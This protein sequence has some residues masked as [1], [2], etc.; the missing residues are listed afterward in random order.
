MTHPTV[1]T[2]RRSIDPGWLAPDRTHAVCRPGC[3][4]M[5][6]AA[7]LLPHS[8][9]LV[10]RRRLYGSSGNAVELHNQAVT[11]PSTGNMCTGTIPTLPWPIRRAG[12]ATFYGSSGKRL[13][14][15]CRHI[16]KWCRRNN[17][18]MRI[19]ERDHPFHYE[20]RIAHGKPSQHP[21]PRAHRGRLRTPVE[22]RSFTPA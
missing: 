5:P 12:K 14:A 16:R 18:A 19:T 10:V 8:R 6:A 11:A 3:A 13:P 15:D 20:T 17:L 22:H 1:V 21:T 4:A 2:S 9:F 7:R